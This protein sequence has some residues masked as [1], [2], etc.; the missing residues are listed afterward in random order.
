MKQLQEKNNKRISQLA[1]VRK[2]NFN[3]SARL[4]VIKFLKELEREDIEI[5]RSSNVTVDWLVDLG[6]TELYFN[7][8]LGKEDYTITAKDSRNEKV[9]EWSDELGMLSEDLDDIVAFIDEFKNSLNSGKKDEAIQE[10]TLN[11][12]KILQNGMWGIEVRVPKSSAKDLKTY[13]MRRGDV[14]TWELV[15][16]DGKPNQATP[17]EFKN[18]KEAQ[19]FIKEKK[20]DKKYT[21]VRITDA[22]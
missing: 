20:L 19:K 4:R 15:G 2:G 21:G 18:E 6:K 3:A 22:A 16:K 5:L 1:E 7:A 12:M 14:W 17:A 11:E 9:E 13:E 10:E 8:S